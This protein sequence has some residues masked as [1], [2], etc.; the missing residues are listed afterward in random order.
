[1]CL[2]TQQKHNKSP[3]NTI[4]P[5]RFGKGRG[6]SEQGARNIGFNE[7]CLCQEWTTTSDIWSLI[8]LL[9]S[10]L[11]P[12]CDT[13]NRKCVLILSQSCAALY[14]RHQK[15][16]TSPNTN[17]ESF[18]IIWQCQHTP[19]FLNIFLPIHLPTHQP[20]YLPSHLP[21]DQPNHRSTYLPTHLPTIYLPTHPS[22]GLLTYR[23]TYLPICA[24][25]YYLSYV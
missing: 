16:C 6:R 21:I 7:Q 5:P 9:L 14:N 18:D 8:F 4:P 1:M 10:K 2:L 20:T 25:I 17:T 13:P 15:S 22:T 24:P 3:E 19:T 11:T 12:A 23:P